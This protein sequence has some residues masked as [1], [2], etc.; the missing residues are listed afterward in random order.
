MANPL[1]LTIDFGTLPMT[2]AGY[3]P[4]EL[5]DRLGIN[6]R[7]FTE[8]AF[9]LFTTGSTAPT[10]DTGPWAA[11]GNTWYYWD[12]GTGS[13]VP[14]LIPQASLKYWVGSA[15]PDPAVYQFWIQLTGPG[16]PLALKTYFGGA[17]VDVYA[18]TL[19]GYQTVA[20]FTAAIA[21]YSTTAQMN[22]AISAAV[23][24]VNAGASIFKAIPSGNQ[25]IVHGGAGQINTDIALG[26]ISFDPDSVFGSSIFTAPANGYYQFFGSV[27][28]SV[29]A[30]AATAVAGAVQFVSS[31]G[32]S[33][34]FNNGPDG[35]EG[36]SQR[37]YVG[38]TILQLSAGDT[39]KLLIAT[40]VDAA[41]TVRVGDN[42]YF[43]GCRLR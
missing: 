17:W 12:S 29:P 11:N 40:V 3:T 35:E 41:C 26:T 2:G 38:S 14:F 5:T 30:G 22:A 31:V 37:F 25:D 42:S 21:N 23:G 19:A 16:S 33:D 27:Q 4:Q 10:S 34:F 39:V 24:G 36:T 15:S 8:Q 7:I 18:A 13:Y 32:D 6:G 1:P 43:T 9:A 28:V 20:A